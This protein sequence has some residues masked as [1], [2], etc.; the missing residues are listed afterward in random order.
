MDDPYSVQGLMA[1]AKGEGQ[2][3]SNGLEIIVT[4]KVKVTKSDA[5]YHSWA[6]DQ[7]NCY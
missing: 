7:H 3:L 6:G 5:K 4:M 1:N 2:H